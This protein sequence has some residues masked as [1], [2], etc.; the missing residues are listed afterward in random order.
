MKELIAKKVKSLLFYG[1]IEHNRTKRFNDENFSSVENL[2][3]YR[4]S[5]IHIYLGEKNKILGIQSFYKNLK[6]EEFPGQVGYNESIKESELKEFVIPSNDHLIGMQIYRDDDVGIKK[7]KFTTKKGKE[8]E[9]GEGG[10]DMILSELNEDKK[11]VILSLSGGY[12]DQLNLLGCKYINMSDYYGNSLGYFELRI[13]LR[14][15]SFKNK[16]DSNINKYK[17]TD[18]VL[19]KTCL[20]PESV[21]NGIIQFCMR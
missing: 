15:E 10:E 8:L 9:V 2:F 16:I 18:K 17:D 5:K 11:N 19:I 21:F 13:K 7:L 20:L 14:N 3:Q 1:I 12:Y 4:L 6:N